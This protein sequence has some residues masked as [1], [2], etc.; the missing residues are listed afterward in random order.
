[1]HKLIH[2]SKPDGSPY[3][4][5]DCPIFQAARSGRATRS[6]D[7]VLFR[8]DGTQF[9]AQ[10]SCSPIWGHGAL[11]GAIV[12]F[13]DITA[14]KRAQQRLQMQ[15]RLSQ[16]LASAS[17][18]DEVSSQ[19][20]ETIG[21]SLDWQLGFFWLRRPRETALQCVQTWHAATS[22]SWPLREATRSTRLERGSG[23]PGRAW[24]QN[25]VAW[26][27]DIHSESTLIRDRETAAR[28]LKSKIAFPIIDRGEVVGVLECSPATSDTLTP[29]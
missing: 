17:H 1:M 29:T 7:D 3:P 19:L 9:A 15:F 11:T 13:L 16:L 12:T 25:D 21:A 4:E 23:L 18:L 14:R 6:E 8:K 26:V 24:E 2:R 28:D 10:Y 22:G 5:A 20:L 27:P